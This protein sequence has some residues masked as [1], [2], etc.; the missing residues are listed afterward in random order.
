MGG[1]SFVVD[2]DGNE[3]EL[4]DR[5]GPMQKQDSHLTFLSTESGFNEDND[6][7]NDQGIAI[8]NWE[9]PDWLL[10]SQIIYHIQ[11]SEILHSWFTPD[12]NRKILGQRPSVTNTKS[13][14]MMEIRILADCDYY[15]DNYEILK[16]ISPKL[17]S[18]ELSS[19]ST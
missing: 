12:V 6:S 8:P 5:N 10:S 2:E 9:D 18:T 1:K 13:S 16:Y 15:Y 7:E 14:N 17:W 4:N 19:S 11:G 3:E